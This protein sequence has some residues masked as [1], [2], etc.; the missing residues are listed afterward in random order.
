[1]KLNKDEDLN[2]GDN[3]SKDE[4]AKPKDKRPY[5]D[6][7]TEEQLEEGLFTNSND[8]GVSNR[9]GPKG[10]QSNINIPGPQEVP[11]QQKVGEDAD[12]D[13][14]HVET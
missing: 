7:L 12:D 9:E 1:M 8:R 14:R 10:G 13:I 11:D 6:K 3:H 2:D 4:Q 5:D